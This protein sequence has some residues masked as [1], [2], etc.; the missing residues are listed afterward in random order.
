VQATHGD[1]ILYQGEVIKAYFSSNSG[2][3]TCTVRECLDLDM[4]PGYLR[5][6]D[7]HPNVRHA[8]GGTWG[9][10]ANLTPSSIREVL[11]SLG[12]NPPSAVTDLQELEQGPSGRTWR[13]RVNLANKAKIDLD[14]TQTR[15]IMHLFGPIRSFL[16][17][18]QPPVG[19]HQPIIG[20]GYGHAVGMSQWGAQLYAQDGWSAQKILQHYYYGVTIKDLGN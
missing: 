4:D 16:Y 1:V 10:K 17:Y 6:V 18:L 15:K 20:Y 7:D 13:L 19:G 3:R 5:E 9:S 14:R 8:P 11:V 2:G 12:I